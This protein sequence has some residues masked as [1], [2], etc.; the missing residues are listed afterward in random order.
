LLAVFFRQRR[1]VLVSFFAVFL[2]I[3]INGLLFP[4]YQSHMKILV[5]RGRVDP[6]TTPMVPEAAPLDRGQISEEDL[7]SEVEL[8][9]DQEILRTSG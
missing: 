7:K 1:L 6:S 8:L 4:S 5:R 3:T 2:G 9:R